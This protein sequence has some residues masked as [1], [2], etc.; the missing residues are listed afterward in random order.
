MSR[1]RRVKHRRAVGFERGRTRLKRL[2]E[3]CR[4]IHWRVMFGER[5]IESFRRPHDQDCRVGY[6]IAFCPI[7]RRTRSAQLAIPVVIFRDEEVSAPS[8]EDLVDRKIKSADRVAARMLVP[9]RYRREFAC[10]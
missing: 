5:R 9:F 1:A 6:L 10:L 8:V 2:V 7:H 4:A 3:P